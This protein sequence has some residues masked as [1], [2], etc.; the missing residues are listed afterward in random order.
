VAEPINE[1]LQDLADALA[2]ERR[3]RRGRIVE[4][5]RDH[6]RSAAESFE[7]Q[8]MSRHEAEAKA[9]TLLG[10]PA[11]FARGFSRAT[12]RDWVVDA[13]AWWSSKVAAILLG[14]GALMV[15]IET[16]AW[17]I[18]TGAVSPRG[19]TVWRTCSDSIG[20]ECVGRWDETQAPALAVA[21]V[22]CLIAGLATLSLY[23]LL[24]RRYSDLELMP[25]LLGV[26]AQLSLAALGIVLLVG[27]ASRSSLDASLRW[28]PVWLP[29]G[30]ASIGAAWLL[31]RSDKDKR[32]GDDWIEPR[33][34]RPRTLLTMPKPPA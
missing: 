34:K 20:G 3:L 30:L 26:G 25:R 8:G 17:S 1:W 29:V 24:R 21:G 11:G 13:I 23:R 16:F 12:W 9:V 7:Q 31:H 6:L 2:S 19:V 5:A 10:E 27:G 18:G 28:I 32:S 33:S 15:L 22:I 14:L 4:E